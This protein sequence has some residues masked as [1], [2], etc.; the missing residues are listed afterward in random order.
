[1][2]L[3]AESCLNKRD[4]IVA[5]NII[6]LADKKLMRFYT[7]Y[8][9]QITVRA[10]VCSGI[11]LTADIYLLTVVDPCRN[12][13]INLFTAANV[14]LAAASVTR[15]FDNF[16]AAAAVITSANTLKVTE[17]STLNRPYLTCSV[18]GRTG[19]G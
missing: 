2:N 13:D 15:F 3:C 5:Q 9:Y 14:A 6:T 11:A 19:R 7:N 16:T 4:R 1:M 8:K 18:T 12:L 10:A 17:R